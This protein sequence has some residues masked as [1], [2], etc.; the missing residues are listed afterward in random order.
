MERRE[1]ELKADPGNR[2]DDSKDQDRTHCRV[3]HN[4]ERGRG[5]EEPA[6][7]RGEPQRRGERQQ[8]KGDQT[9]GEQR[10]RSGDRRTGS[11]ESNQRNSREGGELK[12]DQPGTEVAS[13]GNSRG[14]CRGS[15]NEAHDDGGAT[16][17]LLLVVRPAQQKGQ[18]CGHQG[19]KLK[20]RGHGVCGIHA[21]ATPWQAEGPASFT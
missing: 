17:G 8:A 19:C 4:G 14:A 9:G 12:G 16:R 15:E 3:V 20:G 10:D 2:N 11:P 6:S 13:T 1:G 5:S 7:G 18:R 21:L